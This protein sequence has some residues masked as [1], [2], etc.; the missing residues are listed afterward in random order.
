MAVIFFIGKRMEIT[1]CKKC[2][3]CCKK[4]GPSFHTEDKPLIENGLILLKFLFTIRKGEP[5]NDNIQNRIIFA[6]T[7]IIKIKTYENSETCIFFDN[8]K[9]R[10]KIYRNRPLEC[11]V[12]KCWDTAEIREV[13]SKNRLIRKDLVS[14]IKDL[15][16][17]IEE[18][19]EHCS[20]DK[21]T[22]LIDEFNAGKNDKA[23]K[24]IDEMAGYDKHLRQLL[25]EKGHIEAE[26]TD[27][28]FGRPVFKIL[29][30]FG[31][32]IKGR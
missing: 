14:K 6:D 31:L 20:Y 10:C 21:I 7:D 23:L 2:G 13:Y 22:D 4:G 18:H 19:H 8:T 32:K 26:I 28:L 9:S 1:E 16:D 27:F 29:R 25:L 5:A 24:K 3:T 15:W 30:G 12:L 11:M 17:L